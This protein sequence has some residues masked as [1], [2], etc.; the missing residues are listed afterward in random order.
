MMDAFACA[1]GFILTIAVI[2][3]VRLAVE[4][5]WREREVRRYA[6]GKADALRAIRASDPERDAWARG[7]K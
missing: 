4:A 2:A 7:G 1:V 6:A 5:R 3:A